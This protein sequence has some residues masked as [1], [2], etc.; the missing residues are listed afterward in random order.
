[1]TKS[2]GSI[3]FFNAQKGFGFIKPDNGSKE[4]FCHISNFEGDPES[5]QEGQRVSYKE[6]EGRKGAEA[7]EVTII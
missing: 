4:L 3:K 5:L 2:T 6:G 7:M 1:M